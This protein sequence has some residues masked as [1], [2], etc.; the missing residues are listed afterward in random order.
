[1]EAAEIHWAAAMAEQLQHIAYRRVANHAAHL[2]ER[3]IISLVYN[4][5]RN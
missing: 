1:M 3:C 2:A 4:R 5:N